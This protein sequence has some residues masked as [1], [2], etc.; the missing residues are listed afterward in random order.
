[1]ADVI[2]TAFGPARIMAGTDWPVC[3][4][5]A[6]YPSVLRLARSLVASLSA[7]E[8]T[9]VFASTAARVYGLPS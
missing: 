1:M 7:A 9:A 3:L 6:D 2:L 4:L 5:A 8:Q